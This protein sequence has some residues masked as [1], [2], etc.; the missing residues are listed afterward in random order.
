[1]SKTDAAYQQTDF[2]RRR[3][4]TQRNDEMRELGRKKYFRL[5][6]FYRLLLCCLCL[7]PVLAMGQPPPYCC[8]D[9]T[10]ATCEEIQHCQGSPLFSPLDADPGGTAAC[11][12]STGTPCST[13][14]ENNV[15]GVSNEMPATTM[16]PSGCLIISCGDPLA[17]NYNPTYGPYTP[18]ELQDCIYPVQASNYCLDGTIWSEELGGCIV[19]N[20]TDTDLDGCTGV[21]DM[22]DV[23]ANFGFCLDQQNSGSIPSEFYSDADVLLL[24]DFDGAITDHSPFNNQISTFNYE[25]GPDRNGV[26]DAALLP[27]TDSLV[28]GYFGCPDEVPETHLFLDS[29]IIIAGEAN[30]AYSMSLWYQTKEEA[31]ASGSY[32]HA[33]LSGATVRK[34]PCNGCTT[35]CLYQSSL[36]FWADHYPDYDWSYGSISH[37]IVGGSIAV[38]DVQPLDIAFGGWHHL[39]FV[40]NGDEIK[41]YIDGSVVQDFSLLPD[42]EDPPSLSGS[43]YEY[44]GMSEIEVSL[45]DCAIQYFQGVIDGNSV[46]GLDDILVVNRA[47]SESEIIT[48]LGVDVNQTLIGCL[49][50]TACNFQPDADFASSLCTYEDDCYDCSGALT[51]DLN[52]NEICDTFDPLVGCTNPLYNEYISTATVDD[53][54]CASPQ[55]STDGPCSN[56][57]TIEYFG[58]EYDLVEIG[59]KCWFQEDL[60][61]DRYVNGDFIQTDWVQEV[62]LPNSTA[63]RLYTYHVVMDEREVCPSGWHIAH[64]GVVGCCADGDWDELETLTS[65]EAVKHA[66]HWNGNNQSGFSALP[67][68]GSYQPGEFWENETVY[69][70]WHMDRDT[71]QSWA[72]VQTLKTNSGWQ[73]GGTSYSSMRAIRCVKD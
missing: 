8:F 26:E 49:D 48:L 18:T 51:A 14:W 1:M 71:Y 59:P 72:T 13:Y 21:D 54:S 28:N 32:T 30:E 67:Q 25:L 16:N 56:Q 22:L 4:N 19:K 42:T 61:T 9:A 63:G 43:T 57:W 66:E 38:P 17:S 6:M 52:N 20:P 50:S 10:C 70:S 46:M 35:L 15:Y 37:P 44:Y 64:A 39:A 40:K 53:G 7:L 31:P 58:H 68:F 36:A 60:R 41:V 62:S 11:G 23:L 27:I 12:V 69:A 47:L 33:T 29:I 65:T 45:H 3:N 73:E 2:P 55:I 34:T 5:T 24:I